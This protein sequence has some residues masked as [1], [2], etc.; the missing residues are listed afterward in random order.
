MTSRGRSRRW[1]DLLVSVALP[2]LILGPV[3]FRG[4]YLLRGDMVF[5]PG[6]PWKP[7]WLGLD[8][9][10]P[11]SVP[12][13]AVVWALGKVMP[14]AAVQRFFLA[15]ALVLLALGMARL[16]KE[17]PA[18]ARYAGMVLACW[19]PFVYERFA[20][21]QWPCVLACAALPWL[22]VAAGRL[23]DGGAT[24]GR[25]VAGWMIVLG[26]CAPSMG[27]V[28]ALEL[29]CVL[30][31]EPSRRALLIGVVSVVGA[32]LPWIV[33]SLLRP[34]IIAPRDQFGVFGASAES[35]AG[36]LAS[37]LSLGGIWK[38]SI[39]PSERS[40]AV[41]V[42]LGAIL[43]LLSLVEL[44]RL[45]GRYA[46]CRGLVLA[47]LVSLGIAWLPA[48]GPVQSLLD[49]L[50]GRVPALA[51]LRD[52]TRYLAPAVIAVAVGFGH[53]CARVMSRVA[54]PAGLA[55]AGALA[56]LPVALL[57]SLALGLGGF[58]GT[59]TYPSAW[60]EARRVMA[61]SGESG[62]TVVLPWE[63]SYR[64]FTWTG[65]H[66][67]LDPAPRFFPGDVVIDDR[68]RL[69]TRILGSE[70]PYLRKVG[71]A[72]SEDDAATRLARIGVRWVLV[73]SGPR[74][75]V[76]PFEGGTVRFEAPG[77]R[78]VELGGVRHSVRTTPSRG[79]VLGAD[80]VAISQILVACCRRWRISG[81]G[82]FT[83]GGK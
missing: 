23:R 3:L 65:E 7:A 52:S 43:A 59:S 83:S 62:T 53:L 81:Y 42:V 16:L 32:N 37:V 24:G 36:S 20:I 2:V 29:A 26:V 48:L 1:G 70:D 45:S 47:A 33:P 35:G 60:F 78:L 73:E 69:G 10:V 54:G 71:A 18:P 14:G 8:G 15:G 64:G 4:G 6:Q 50:V 55:A 22:L 28:G 68:I 66:A 74:T 77:L 39:V 72:L 57:P 75:A 41:I 67:V 58:L 12:M 31:T 40:V 5:V 44:W 63:G 11:R 49:D 80:F 76:T 13:D 9:A 17:L 82:S 51:I 61:G 38:S 27:L 21:G 46:W 25:S 30:L 34:G 79:W 19:N 56:L